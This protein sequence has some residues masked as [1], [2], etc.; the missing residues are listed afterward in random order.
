MFHKLLRL[1]KMALTLESLE[2][3]V[4][5][6]IAQNIK[7]TLTVYNGVESPANPAIHT[8]NVFCGYIYFC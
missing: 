2:A 4:V 1:L 3:A 5:M 6:K 8:A 7:G